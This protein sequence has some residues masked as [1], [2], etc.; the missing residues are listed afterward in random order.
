[1]SATKQQDR[2]LSTL[3]AIAGVALGS[4]IVTSLVRDLVETADGINNLSDRLSLL[5]GDTD[6]AIA[7]AGAVAQRTGQALGSTGALYARKV[8]A[9]RDFGVTKQDAL[10]LTETINQ[11][12]AVSSASATSINDHAANAGPAVWHAGRGQSVAEP[13]S[14]HACADHPGHVVQTQTNPH[15][16]AA[17]TPQRLATL[18]AERSAVTRAA[19]IRDGLDPALLAERQAQGRAL[20]AS[21]YSYAQLAVLDGERDRRLTL[22]AGH[23]WALYLPVLAGNSLTFRNYPEGRAFLDEVHEVF[24]RV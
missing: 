2:Q 6:S 3:S 14:R 1:M 18:R 17:L 4:G 20:A 11:A 9:G 10:S 22:H 16:D 8:T 23:D 5:G 19:A 24:L 12:V 7:G 13:R 21:R 15:R